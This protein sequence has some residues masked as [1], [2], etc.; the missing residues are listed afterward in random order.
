M[1]VINA[2]SNTH[3]SSISQVDCFVTN[4]STCFCSYKDIL[5]N[6]ISY[7]YYLTTLYTIYLV[8]L[9]GSK[10]LIVINLSTYNLKDP[11]TP[12]YSSSNSVIR[13]INTPFSLRNIDQNDSSVKKAINL[14]HQNCSLTITLILKVQT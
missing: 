3:N 11:S 6:D 13:G 14:N 2:L 7:S 1:L 10:P 5:S 8:V 12:L 9:L 4:L